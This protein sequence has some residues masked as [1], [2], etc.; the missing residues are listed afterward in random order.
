M[1]NAIFLDASFWI[2]IRDQRDA[3]FPLAQAIFGQA[4]RARCSLVTTALVAAETH[5]YFSKSHVRFRILE[6]MESVGAIQ[7][8]PLNAA[9]QPTAIKLLR[10]FRDKEFS[11]CDAIS[12]VVMER[13]NIR[14]ALSFDRHFRQYGKIELIRRPE[15]I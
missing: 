4:G 2:A 10:A 1:N 13:L 8:E 6:D 7:I 5:A 14:R 15:E 11:L 3:E 9:D 12:F